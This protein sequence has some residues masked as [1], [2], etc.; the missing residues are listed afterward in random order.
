MADIL[1]HRRFKWDASLVKYVNA[2][3]TGDIFAKADI[4]GSWNHYDSSKNIWHLFFWADEDAE[5]PESPD[6]TENQRPAKVPL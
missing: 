2:Y 5:V 4:E 1:W 3:G 6:F